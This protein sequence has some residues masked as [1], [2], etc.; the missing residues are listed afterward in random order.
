MAIWGDNVAE[1][2]MLDDIVGQVQYF[3][4]HVFISRHRGIQVK[5]FYVYGHELLSL[6]GYD[7]VDQKFDDE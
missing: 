5:V 4:S 1:F 6:G 2:I 3:Q 7:A